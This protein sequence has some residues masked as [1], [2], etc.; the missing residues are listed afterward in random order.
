MCFEQQVARLFRANVELEPHLLP[1]LPTSW[2]EGILIVHATWSGPSA[3][4]LRTL[5]RVVAT[6]QRP[7]QV[8]IADTNRLSPDEQLEH[9]GRLCHG[10]GET[11]VIKHGRPGPM[12]SHYANLP[13]KLRSWLAV[14][15]PP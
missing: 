3:V 13:E 1:P 15:L 10:W 2:S 14:E 5:A 8:Y 11:F 9:F 4:V 7:P 12:L 6:L